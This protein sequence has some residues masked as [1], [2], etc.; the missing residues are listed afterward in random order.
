MFLFITLNAKITWHFPSQKQLN[1][2]FEEKGFG[3]YLSNVG[4]CNATLPLY[5]INKMVVYEIFIINYN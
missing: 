1:P 4:H 3:E 2:V 5:H